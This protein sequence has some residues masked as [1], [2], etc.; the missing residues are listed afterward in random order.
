M[1]K[2]LCVLIIMVMAVSFSSCK[3]SDV[4]TAENSTEEKKVVANE[5]FLET[6]EGIIK[7][8]GVEKANSGLCDDYQNVRIV[9]FEFTN[10]LGEPKECQNIFDIKAFQNGVQIKYENS[11]SSDGGTQYELVHNYFLEALNGGVINF[12][13]MYTVADDSPITIFID[14]KKEAKTSFEIELVNENEITVDPAVIV[15]KL[16]GEWEIEGETMT[17]TGNILNAG[18]RISGEYTVN[19]EESKI[20]CKMQA[21]DGNVTINMPYEFDGEILKV[22]NNKGAELV[23]K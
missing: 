16:Q 1:K 4:Q 19:T 17:F 18:G 8:V 20:V 6:D 23:K 12:A 7:F 2:I 3:N 13:R 11:Y 22:F 9:K 15:E 14:D 10:K 5:T 21:T